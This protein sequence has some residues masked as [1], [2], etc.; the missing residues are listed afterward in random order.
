MRARRFLIA[1]ESEVD[2]GLSDVGLCHVV[3]QWVRVSLRVPFVP[4]VLARAGDSPIRR[5]GGRG[6]RRAH[7]G[8]P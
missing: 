4:T 7:P 6:H 8:V 3:E 2:G 1:A 5:P